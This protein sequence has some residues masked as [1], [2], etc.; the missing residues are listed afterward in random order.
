MNQT[1]LN[2]NPHQAVRH[3]QEEFWNALK[4][5]DREAFEKIL[6]IDFIARTPGQP[7]QGRA[8]FI[9]SLIGFP[10]QVHSIGS[11]NLEVHIWGDIAVT[12]G[13]QSAEIELPDGQTKTNTIAITNVFQRQKGQWILKLAHAIPLE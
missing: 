5:K 3:V 13:V 1:E 8:G 10:A 12:T 9:Q 4:N 6:D 7:N 11:D 2:E